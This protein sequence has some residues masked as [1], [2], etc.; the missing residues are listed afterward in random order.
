ME[1]AW[2]CG[3]CARQL[4]SACAAP[5]AAGKGE[6]PICAECGGIVDTLTVAR[7]AAAPFGT[8]LGPAIRAAL[9]P[10]ALLLA[11]VVACTTEYFLT[12]G[13]QAWL[14]GRALELGWM[15]LVFRI[16]ARGLPPFRRPTYADLAAAWVG[17]LARLA[18]SVGFLA[19]GAAWLV[20]EGRKS[21]PLTS[22][23]AWFWAAVAIA[24]VPPALVAAGVEGE[25]AR[26]LGPWQLLDVEKRIGRDLRSVRALVAFW[27]ALELV[28]AFLPPFDLQADM[29]LAFHIGVAAAIRVL[30][31]VA[32]ALLASVAGKLVFTYAEELEHGDPATYRIPALAGARPTGTWTP[33]PPDPALL[34]A[35]AKRHAPIEL[36]EPLD[37]LRSALARGDAELALSLFTEDAKLRLQ[38]A[39]EEHLKVA[40]MMAGRGQPELA[41]EVLR[42]L[43]LRAPNDPQ[44]PRAMVILAR[45]CAER[46]GAADEASA[47]YRRVLERFPASEAAAYARQRLG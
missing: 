9:T 23:P 8:Q 45:L 27:V 31:V 41:A 38:L 21:V 30:S 4:C 5:A 37:A 1:A 26:W 12:F 19:A 24:L 15:L 32:L 3:A 43:L 11:M 40:Q 14:L 2:H 46:L 7:S 16:A 36:E 34:E 28:E 18:L 17:P 33:P 25:G 42:A 44:A 29:R 6:L 39:P 10:L 47:L 20:D 22:G 13:G 35:E